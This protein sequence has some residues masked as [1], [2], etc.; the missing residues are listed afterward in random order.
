LGTVKSESAIVLNNHFDGI[1]FTYGL[2]EV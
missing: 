1:A 2:C